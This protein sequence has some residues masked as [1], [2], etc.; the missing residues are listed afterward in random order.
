VAEEN[1][2][3]VFLIPNLGTEGLVGMKR[4]EQAFKA[5]SKV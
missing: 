5:L 4:L 3:K 2:E 1:W